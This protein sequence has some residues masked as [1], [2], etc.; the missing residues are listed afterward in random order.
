MMINERYI[1]LIRL[2]II[3]VYGFKLLVNEDIDDIKNVIYSFK[4]KFVFICVYSIL[5]KYMLMIYIKCL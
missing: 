2:I 5:I 3:N 1:V 4:I